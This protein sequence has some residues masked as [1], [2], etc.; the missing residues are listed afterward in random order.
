MDLKFNDPRLRDEGWVKEQSG[1]LIQRFPKKIGWFMEKG[2]QPHFYQ[3]WFHCATDEDD[4]LS[5]WRS[6]V[7][8]RRGGKTLSAA[9]EMAFYTIHPKEWWKDAHGIDSEEDAWWWA[10]SADHKVGLPSLLMFRSVLKSAGYLANKDYKENRQEKFFEFSNARVDYRSGDNPSSLVGA[11]LHGIWVDEAAKLQTDEA[12][13]I[14]RPCLSDKM[15]CGIF[16]TTP[17]GRNWFYREFHDESTYADPDITRIE[18]R[19]IDNPYFRQ[20]E[21][22]KLQET[23]HPLA[24][25][26]EFMASFSAFA[27]RDLPGDWLE[28][29]YT[30]DDLPRVDGKIGNS[31]DCFDLDYYIGVDPAISVAD[32]ADFFGLSVIGVPKGTANRA[33]VIESINE[34]ISFAEQLDKIREY[35]LL[36]RPV[37]IAI[38]D[39]A[40]QRAL[41]QQ[42]ARLD[43]AP[44]VIGVPAKGTKVER[45]MS[46]SPTFRVGKAQVQATN[47]RFVEEWVNYDVNNKHAEDDVLDSVEIALR[48]AGVISEEPMQYPGGAKATVIHPDKWIHDQQ[49]KPIPEE[50]WDDGDDYLYGSIMNTADD[51]WYYE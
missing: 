40:Y 8:G 2:Y 6:L 24:F 37:Y 33:Y 27:G 46:M 35:E 36:Y 29:F 48:V 12:W 26:R 25:Q 17:E 21:W 14:V 41:V 42:A 3:L 34:H 19:S 47:K 10:L 28:P 50:D 39:V 7:A 31:P 32:N 11:G 13:T 51:A 22:A 9:W 49:P 5:R 4:R 20:E 15:G 38:E 44:N 30:W 1:L 43:V 23:Y 18:Y 45:I 16:T